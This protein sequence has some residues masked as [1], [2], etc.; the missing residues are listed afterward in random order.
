[1]NDW[2]ISYIEQIINHLR[3]ALD[4]IYK[5][6]T[7][8]MDVNRVLEKEQI[9]ENVIGM[10]FVTCQMYISGT[11]SDANLFSQHKLGKRELLKNNSELIPGTSIT[12]VE[13]C[14]A[15]ANYYKH[16]E[17]W[18]IID[19]WNF[20]TIQ[21]LESAGIKISLDRNEMVEVPWTRILEILLPIEKGNDLSALLPPISDWRNRTLSKLVEN[22]K[23]YRP[24]RGCS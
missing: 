18:K 19:K 16:N 21:T 6:K 10:V 3:N 5:T 8:E 17:E 23:P 13:L 7:G 2:R 20:D 22:I 15:Y 12:Y 11:I 24:T 4:E 9:I 1:M 14:D